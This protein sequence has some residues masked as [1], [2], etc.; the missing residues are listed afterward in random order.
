MTNIQTLE[1]ADEYHW[2]GSETA[3]HSDLLRRQ[4]TSLESPG[5]VAKWRTY[6]ASNTCNFLNT[7]HMLCIRYSMC[8]NWFPFLLFTMNTHVSHGS[9]CGQGWPVSSRPPFC[10]P[11][12]LPEMLTLF[13]GSMHASE[14]PLLLLTLCQWLSSNQLRLHVDCSIFLRGG[15]LEHLFPLP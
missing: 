10:A 4:T 1:N 15:E 6:F 8:V 12:P 3:L 14:F 9:S 5:E 11:V 7:N 13:F 2:V